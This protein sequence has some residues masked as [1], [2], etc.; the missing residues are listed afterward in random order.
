MCATYYVAVSEREMR[1]IIDAVKK[2]YK[3]TPV[4]EGDI[5]PKY[6]APVLW[7]DEGQIAARPMYWGLPLE[8]K[9]SVNFNARVENLKRVKL[10]SN[11]K[12][13]VIP[14]NGFYEWRNEVN[15]K[16]KFIFNTAG[17]GLTFIAGIYDYYK[18]ETG[19]PFRF[20]MLTRRPSSAFSLYHNREPVVLDREECD[21][22]LS[23]ESKDFLLRS[24]LNLSVRAV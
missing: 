3:N 24:P 2:N 18:D 12:P 5:Y 9:K 22:W 20:T 7:N 11:A 6:M 21:A 23:S 4:K 15:G 16:Q 14:T 10:Y 19:Y 8:G 13:V 17:E 1:E